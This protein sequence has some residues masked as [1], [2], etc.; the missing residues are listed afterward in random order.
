MRFGSA[1]A[2]EPYAA[3]RVA[4]GVQ[5]STQ[6]FAELGTSRAVRDALSR[7]GITEPF[8]VQRLVIGDV[9]AGRDVLVKSPTGSG[10][11]LAF[12]VPMVDRVDAGGPRPAALVLAPTRELATQIVDEIREVAH[13]R[14]LR[15]TAVYGGVG[16]EKQAKSA[17]LSHILVATPGRLEDLLARRAFTLGRIRMLVLDEADR[18][19]DMG[20]RPAIDRI[21]N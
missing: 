21:V 13:S 8:P 19:L 14:A 10:K 9:L 4:K 5:M 15:V 20:F 11:T 6:T 16:L 17:A 2:S 3:S 12:G 7:R 18:M 1:I